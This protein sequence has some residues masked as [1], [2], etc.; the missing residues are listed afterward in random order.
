MT[1][2]NPTQMT[3]LDAVN[4]MLSIISMPPLNSLD[5]NTNADVSLARNKLA[6]ES[7]RVQ[8]TGWWFNTEFEYPLNVNGNNEIELAGNIASVDANPYVYTDIDPVQRGARLYDRKNHTY[9]F[10]NNLKATVILLLPFDELPQVAREYIA[11]KAGRLFQQSTPGS[12]ER[13]GFAEEDEFKALRELRS[14]EAQNADYSV[15]QSYSVSNVLDRSARP[16][17]GG[18]RVWRS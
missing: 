6:E 14:K 4:R 7:V 17:R 11:V 3:E 10:T 8:T 13:D 2:A 9:T 5:G 18:V 1:A 12:T 15:F 16:V